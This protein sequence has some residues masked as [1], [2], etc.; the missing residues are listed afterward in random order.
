MC[1]FFYKRLEERC[2]FAFRFLRLLDHLRSSNFRVVIPGN[3]RS[4]DMDFSCWG[5]LVVK[6]S[7]NSHLTFLSPSLL[8]GK[9]PFVRTRGGTRCFIGKIEAFSWLRKTERLCICNSERRHWQPSCT[10]VSIVIGS[11]FTTYWVLNNY[12]QAGFQCLRL[13]R[14]ANNR[15]F[16]HKKI[17]D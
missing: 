3:E 2:I 17:R 10:N 16:S 11:H 12:F 5:T 6:V 8:P 7:H 4:N 15:V 1:T 9:S 14:T 13:S